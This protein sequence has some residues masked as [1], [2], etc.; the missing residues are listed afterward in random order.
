[1]ELSFY[2]DIKVLQHEKLLYEIES[3][4]GSASPPVHV[5][6]ELT[7]ACNFQCKFCWWHDPTRKIDHLLPNELDVTGK[8]QFNLPRLLALIDEFAEM[9]VQ[10]I[11]F[12]GSGDPLLFPHVEH[13]LERIVAQGIQFGVTSNLAMKLKPSAL[14]SL[15]HASWI[16][17][18]M[19]A[20]SKDVYL[21]VNSPRAGGEASAYERV[22]Q[23]VSTLLDSRRELK[24]PLQINASM[25]ITEVNRRD[26]R[27][28]AELAANLGVNSISFRPDVPPEADEN[29][30]KRFPDDL[31]ASIDQAH[32]DLSNDKFRVY[33]DT[34]WLK[35]LR[36]PDD[37]DLL[38]FYSNHSTFVAATGE[39]YPC[40]YTHGR[41]EFSMGNILDM[42]FQD[43]WNSSQRRDNYRN[44]QFSHCPS[45]P[46]G[47][48]NRILRELYDG[49]KSAEDLFVISDTPA[50]FI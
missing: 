50:V 47:K 45:C 49:S 25:V 6:I 34:E 39:V 1:M 28:A 3:N 7:E 24:A 23:N 11:S 48:T 44:L 19:N 46:Y 32:C 10:A 31:Q 16:R 22:V 4:G 29:S 12:T 15:T 17:W 33:A 38:C 9:G 14:Y 37:P 5:R 21:A 13:V 42:S 2:D 18:S 27:A 43:F 40:C 20:G 35:D 36:K 8:R 26:V 30:Y 41:R